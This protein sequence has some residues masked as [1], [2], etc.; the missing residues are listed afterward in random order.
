MVLNAGGFVQIEFDTTLESLNLSGGPYPMPLASD[1]GNVLGD[2]VEGYGFVDSEVTITLS[3]QRPVDP[4]PAS[5]G[6]AIASLGETPSINAARSSG[7]DPINPDELDGEQFFVDSFFDVFFDITVTDVD[8]RPGR[9]FAGF[10]DGASIPLQ[11]NGPAFLQ[12]RYDAIFDK[13]APNFG[14]IPPPQV[15]PYIGHF[16]IEIPLGG[17]INGNGEDDKIKFTIASHAAGDENRVFTT[18]PDGTVIDEFDSA[19][20]L[21]GAVVDVSTDPPFTLG[22]GSPGAPAFSGPGALTGPTTATSTLVTPIVTKDPGFPYVDANNDKLF[23]PADGDVLLDDGELNDG[24]F[25]TAIP[26]GPDYTVAIAGAGLRIHGA[27]I[28]NFSQDFSADGGMTVNTDLTATNR[29]MLLTSRSE[30]VEL[31]DPTLHARNL[32]E[33]N[34][35]IDIVSTDDVLRA[36]GSESVIR[37]DA[38]EKILLRGTRVTA[39][40]EVEM[41]AGDLI[42]INPSAANPAV[43]TATPNI[44]G[45][46]DLDAS[47]IE[48]S[49][50]QIA[51][52]RNIVM[53][54]DVINA[55]ESDLNAN[56]YGPGKIDL[57]A[58]FVI[59]APFAEMHARQQIVITADTG[60]VDATGAT[61]QASAGYGGSVDIAGDAVF[62]GGATV[63]AHAA[64]RVDAAVGIAAPFSTLTA[65]PHYLGRVALAT[66]GIVDVNSATIN[67]TKD[68]DIDAGGELSGNAAIMN[69]NG[70]SQGTIDIESGGDIQLTGAQLK[71]RK[72]VDLEAVDSIFAADSQL[73]A[74]GAVF[75]EVKATAGVDLILTDAVIRARAL[76]D[77]TAVGV[78]D[79]TRSSIG[80]THLGAGDLKVAASTIIVTDAVLKAPDDLDLL[81]TVVGIPTDISTGFLPPV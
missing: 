61:I 77:L 60:P 1:P 14:L 29:D 72:I 8:P 10:P 43:V 39:M 19:A 24:F 79:L 15:A 55:V 18:L 68:V 70:H 27:A 81:G 17:D 41:D 23:N 50:A 54:A 12:S 49:L 46:V 62:L 5:T 58:V 57:H 44:F 78:A 28:S 6:Q 67:A 4:G 37:L 36:S 7:G 21:Q 52:I 30:N 42:L 35:A 65:T 16:D 47:V 25:D 32:L 80:I 26:E 73:L 2:S 64:V 71:A 38:G 59:F 76:I 74:Q 69:A 22:A 63:A 48:V 31:D 34:A 3:S 53:N 66:P 13:D 20:F 51:A 45:K 40:K 11:D 56:T 75:S 9:D 33:I